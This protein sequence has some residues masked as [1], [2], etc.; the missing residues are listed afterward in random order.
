MRELSPLTFVAGHRGLVG[1]A[2]VRALTE[3]GAPRPIVID[4][5]ELDLADRRAVHDFFRRERPAVVY[6]AAAKVGGIL[7]NDTDRWDF[8]YQNLLIETSVIGAALEVG[9]EKLVFFGSSCIY[10]RLS[11]QPMPEE[12]LLTGP[13]ERTNEPYAIAK[14]AGVKLVEAANAQYGRRWISIMPTNLYGPGDNF[15]LHTSHVLPAMIRKFHAAKLAADT[16]IEAPPLLWGTGRV[17]REFLHVDDLARAALHVVSSDV[18]GLVNVGYGSDVTV[19]ELATIVGE[20]VGYRGPLQW[21]ASKPDGTPRK[22]LDSARVFATGWRPLIDLHSGV[23]A[24]YEWFLQSNDSLRSVS[25]AAPEGR[26]L[27]RQ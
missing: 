8:L 20:V 3:S 19:R 7:A 17:Q 21:D 18:T 12:A 14:I 15:D 9:V 13:L 5:E 26:D 27:V 23:R 25:P 24:T 6:L 16:G 22:L 2:I 4:R 1:S 11:P 10:P